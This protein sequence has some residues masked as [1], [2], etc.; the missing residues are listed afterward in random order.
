MI[1]GLHFFTL[2]MYV[3]SFLF[4]WNDLNFGNCIA[5]DWLWNTCKRKISNSSAYWIRIHPRC[6]PT[7]QK[8]LKKI[9]YQNKFLISEW[10][11][12]PNKRE[13]RNHLKIPLL[14]KTFEDDLDPD[15][16]QNY[17]DLRHCLVPIYIKN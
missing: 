4:D 12:H 13:K 11:Y 8:Q 10:F 15:P 9:D 2:K 17:L 14:L 7:N 1:L 6:K 3:S 5:H 16:H